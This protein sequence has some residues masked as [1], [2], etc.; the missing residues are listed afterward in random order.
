MPRRL[1]TIKYDGTD[2][3]GWQIQNNGVTVQKTVQTALESVVGEL[4]NGVTGCS[5]TDSGVHANMFC[6]HF[7]TDYNISD[8]KLVSALNAKLPFDI[9]ALYCRGVPEDFHAR[10]S[11]TG[12]NYIYKI[13]NSAVRDP[14]KYKYY[15]QVNRRIDEAMLDKACKAFVGTHD[16]IGFCST[17]SSVKTTVR[18][19]TECSVTRNADDVIFSISADGF[20]YNMVRII[21][22]TLLDVSAGK[23][24]VC[25]LPDIIDSRNRNRAGATAKPHGLY[26]NK[27]FYNL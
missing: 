26:L 1:L 13:Y 16:F 23:I 9:S 27:V 5:R 24:R 22:G 18:T 3:C 8:D 10:Y 15:L 2:Y 14:F 17:G 6:L 4:K 12:K 20:L 19:V 25:D 21:V 7:D 11:C